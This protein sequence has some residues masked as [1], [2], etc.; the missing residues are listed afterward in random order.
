MVKM[1][2]WPSAPP[3]ANIRLTMGKAPARNVRPPAK[4]CL[5]WLKPTSSRVR[6]LAEDHGHRV[7]LET[8]PSSIDSL[9][10]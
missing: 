1:L 3:Q 8:E 5:K 6:R 4:L 2:W 9:L 10:I 7:E